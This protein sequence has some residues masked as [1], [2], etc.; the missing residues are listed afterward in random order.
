ME[1][2]HIAVE[3]AHITEENGKPP[4]YLLRCIQAINKVN[5]RS[6]QLF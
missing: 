2:A 5:M 1:N 4:K 3:N 6:D